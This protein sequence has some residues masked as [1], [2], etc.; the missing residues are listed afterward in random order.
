VVIAIIA[1]LVGLLLPAVQKAREAAARASCQNNLKQIVLAIHNCADTHQQVLPVG[2][3]MYPTFGDNPVVKTQPDGFQLD[4]NGFGAQRDAP[5]SGYGSMFF[6]ILPY[7]EQYSVYQLS[8]ASTDPA[9]LL[10]GNP[11][12]GWA[13]GP[14]TYSCWNEKSPP[15]NGV[16]GTPIKTY[17]CPSD[18]TNVNGKQGAGGW[19]A[20]SYAYNYQV[21]GVDW[22][23]TNQP[24]KFPASIQDG[25]SNTIFIAEKYAAPSKDPWSLDWGGNTWW[26]WSPKFAIDIVGPSSMFLVQPT[27]LYC[28][29]TTNVPASG[30]HG[31][32]PENICAQLAVTGHT[33]GMCTALGDGSV[34]MLSP[35]MAGTT[36]WAAVT[37]AGGETLP[38]DW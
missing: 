14:Q 25:L 34:R 2:M 28:D 23:T 19:G 32:S 21:F 31:N 16:V 9:D 1:I 36:W 5:G 26:E 27:V 18:P 29:A 22:D 15:P 30:S 13:G 33:G 7:I 12:P 3:G 17:N 37:P 6:H 11:D 35:T 38:S 24:R 8:V 10:G 4:A 20:G